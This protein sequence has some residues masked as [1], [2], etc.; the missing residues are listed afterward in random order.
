MAA[1]VVSFKGKLH[2]SP[3]FPINN[4]TEEKVWKKT[5]TESILFYWQF[6]NNEIQ[7]EILKHD[8]TIWNN[9][10]FFYSLAPK[11][12]KQK[13]KLKQKRKKKFQRNKSKR[14]T[15]KWRMMA[16]HGWIDWIYNREYIKRSFICWSVFLM[17][18]YNFGVKGHVNC[19]YRLLPWHD[20]SWEYCQ[21]I[22]IKEGKNKQQHNHNKSTTHNLIP[23]NMKL[24]V[25]RKKKDLHPIL[26]N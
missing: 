23:H 18:F 20:Q 14:Q 12:I 8:R 13:R 25:W 10:L 9:N 26:L 21:R 22:L 19:M 11:M 24:V 2:L 3:S 15:T 5:D 17:Y 1:R 7:L 4:N 16:W 6:I